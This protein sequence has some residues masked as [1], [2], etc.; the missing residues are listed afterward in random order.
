MILIQ[1]PP[2]LSKAVSDLATPP[3]P[4]PLPFPSCKEISAI[5]K[6]GP[7]AGLESSW[8]TSE[9]NEIFKRTGKRKTEQRPL[10][11]KA[12]IHNCSSA[13]ALYWNSCC[14]IMVTWYMSLTTAYLCC[15]SASIGTT[16]VLQRRAICVPSWRPLNA[17]TS[18]IISHTW[19]Q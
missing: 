4:P 13:L 7:E 10:V 2:P 12:M 3:P 16:S 9:S 19:W 6:V 5:A 1:L 11:C 15:I 18:N 8:S 17:I 14:V